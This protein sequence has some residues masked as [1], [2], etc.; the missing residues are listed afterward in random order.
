MHAN[1]PQTG[2]TRT[3]AELRQRPQSDTLVMRNGAGWIA[4]W[5][6][7]AASCEGSHAPFRF[8]FVPCH[9]ACCGRDWSSGAFYCV[10]GLL[11]G[12][13]ELAFRRRCRPFT[14]PGALSINWCIEHSR[15]LKKHD[16]SR[17]VAK[18]GA[19][20]E[21]EPDYHASGSNPIHLHRKRCNP[22]K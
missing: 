19:I 17:L 10:S 9:R 2:R 14:V 22:L 1:I 18:C 7:C 6:L 3:L 13:V 20:G 12:A 21:V 8:P 15:H 4:I 5:C 11:S 16:R